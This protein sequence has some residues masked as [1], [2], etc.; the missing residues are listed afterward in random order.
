MRLITTTAISLFLTGFIFA[1]TNEKANESI[2]KCALAESISAEFK[3]ASNTVVLTEDSVR[4]K[5]KVKKTGDILDDVST[6]A[7]I[8]EQW[9]AHSVPDFDKQFKQSKDQIKKSKSLTEKEKAF[10][11]DWLSH[12]LY[13]QY[14]Y[15]VSRYG[16]IIGIEM[17]ELANRHETN[18]IPYLRQIAETEL[19]KEL[20]VPTCA[21]IK[22]HY[23][24][25][26]TEA[27]VTLSMPGGLSDDQKKAWL[28]N[29]IASEKGPGQAGKKWAIDAAERMLRKQE[30]VGS[31]PAG[32]SN[33][34]KN[35]RSK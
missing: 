27:W 24:N 31:M 2:K 18:A 16:S 14:S 35:V 4:N 13:E 26:A 33:E 12:D 21:R 20:G 28:D 19:P 3:G 8:F 7:D 6:Y 29:F 32:T 10:K 17:I 22:S 25:P 30:K 34:T 1:Q 23:Q 11:L 15:P 5:L 9:A